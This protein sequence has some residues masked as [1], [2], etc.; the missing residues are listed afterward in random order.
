MDERRK[1]QQHKKV[2]S[3]YWQKQQERQEKIRAISAI[4]KRKNVAESSEGFDDELFQGLR[5][6]SI[7]ERS[8]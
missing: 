6:S 5:H 3:L 2:E 7:A 1:E 8:K 4:G